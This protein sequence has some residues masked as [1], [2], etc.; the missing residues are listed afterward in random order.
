MDDQQKEG[1]QKPKD[2]E[3]KGTEPRRKCSL[4]AAGTF[5]RY[6]EV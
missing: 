2:Q 6:S 3:M 1:W 5:L 4:G